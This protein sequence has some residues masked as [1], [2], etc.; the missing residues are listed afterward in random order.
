MQPVRVGQVV[1]PGEPAHIV[2]DQR[3]AEGDRLGRDQQ[4]V[5]ADRLA[6]ALEARAQQAVGR[7]R[8]ASNGRT[9]RA[10]STASSCAA[11]RGEPRL[12]AP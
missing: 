7:I 12:A 3:M 5:G 11:S 8:G 4:I 6:G 9:S 10:P 2:G 1:E